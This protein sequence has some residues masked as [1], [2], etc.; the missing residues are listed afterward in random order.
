MSSVP[1][2]FLIYVLANVTCSQEP[3]ILPLT[4]CLEVQIG[5]TTNYTLFVMNYCNRT[6]VQIIDVS[7]TM[8]IPGMNIS[9][10]F[11]STTNSSLSYVNLQWTPQLNQ[12]GFQQFCA[13]AYNRFI[14]P[15]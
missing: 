2:Q 6:K 15:F 14:S 1:V 3:V 10:I 8:N 12:I 13:M 5:V 7:P 9:Q 4:G 11:N